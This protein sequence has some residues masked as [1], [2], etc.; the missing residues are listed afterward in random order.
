MINQLQLLFKKLNSINQDTAL[1]EMFDWDEENVEKFN[2]E[3]E[4][5]LAIHQ[6]ANKQALIDFLVETARPYTLEYLQEKLESMMQNLVEQCLSEVN[7][8]YESQDN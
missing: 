1:L 7:N 6:F 2:K 5:A 4:R 8:L 3:I